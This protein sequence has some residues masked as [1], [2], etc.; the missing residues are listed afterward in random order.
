[1]RAGHPLDHGLGGGWVHLRIIQ[2]IFQRRFGLLHIVA[3]IEQP[4]AVG[5]ND[6]VDLLRLRRRETKVVN[7]VAGPP[8]HVRS[9]LGEA[10]HSGREAEDEN[11]HAASHHS[12][13]SACKG[14]VAGGS[15]F[16]A[17]RPTSCASCASEILLGTAG[18]FRS[19]SNISRPPPKTNKAAAAEAQRP[20]CSWDHQ[21]TGSVS[22][23]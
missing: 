14:A 2:K 5:A 18:G 12:S 15:E 17:M 21:R 9:I 8:R 10:H 7:H 6:L 20:S 13:N 11:A 23:S 4:V 22:F 16:S 3:R 1:A 19:C